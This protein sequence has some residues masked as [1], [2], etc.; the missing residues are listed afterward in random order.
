MLY[1]RVT[2]PDKFGR[3]GSRCN[4]VLTYPNVKLKSINFALT[5]ASH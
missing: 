4:K 5:K 2:K 1:T 3:N